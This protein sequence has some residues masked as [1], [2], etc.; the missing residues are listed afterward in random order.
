VKIRENAIN[1]V[2]IWNI[3][4]NLKINVNKIL[5]NFWDSFKKSGTIPKNNEQMAIYDL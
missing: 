2:K 3:K 4:K 1:F 5:K